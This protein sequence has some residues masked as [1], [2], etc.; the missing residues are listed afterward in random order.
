MSNNYEKLIERISRTSGLEKEEIEKKVVAKQEKISG[1]ISKEG[2]AQIVAS[3]LGIS[4]DSEKS[5][6]D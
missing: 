6:I 3:E 4:L 2:A 1:L 5:K